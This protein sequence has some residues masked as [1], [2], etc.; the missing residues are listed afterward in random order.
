M[1]KFHNEFLVRVLDLSRS[2]NLILYTFSPYFIAWEDYVETET[3]LEI[4]FKIMQKVIQ[5]P[6]HVL[7]FAMV[8]N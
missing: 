5:I 7:Y 3:F 4:V 2:H 6:I 8:K 1:D